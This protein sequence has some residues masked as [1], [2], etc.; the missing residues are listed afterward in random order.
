MELLL[1]PIVALIGNIWV[2]I[3]RIKEKHSKDK[4]SLR[5]SSYKDMIIV[6]SLVDAVIIGFVVLVLCLFELSWYKRVSYIL[7]GLVAEGLMVGLLT[8]WFTL[9][10]FLVWC[11][12]AAVAAGSIWGS[13]RYEKYLEDITFHDHFNYEIYTPFTENSPVKT[14]DE[15][16]TLHFND[17]K[18]V[19]QMDGATALYPVYAAFAQAVYPDSMNDMTPYDVRRIVSCSTTTNAYRSIVDGRSDV[20]FVAGPSEEQEAYAKEH[21]VELNYTPIGREAFVFFVHP[22][23][24][25]SGL[26]IEEIRSIYSGETTRWDQLGVKNLG[27]ILAYQRDEGSGSQTALERFV[28]KDTPLMPATVETHLDGMGDIVESVSAYKNHRN[29]IGFSFRFYCTALM[30][31]FDVKLLSI[32]GIAPTVENIENG[33]YPL[34]SS[35]Y[36]VTRSDADDKTLALVEWICGPQ[37]QKLIEETGYTPIG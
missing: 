13:N 10:R 33:T 28:M 37:G 29:A 21:G 9:K 17:L 25:V 15:V 32:N 22:D 30:K 24:P 6:M 23:N 26:T 11:V 36:A 4:D 8:Q 35:F 19:P 14:L 3:V 20:I 2:I 27:K 18:T 7:S 12:C 34:A 1:L 31:D 16:P 5:D